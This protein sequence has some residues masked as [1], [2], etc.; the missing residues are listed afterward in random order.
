VT[1][2]IPKWLLWTC[3]GSLAVAAIA[4]AFLLGRS[5]GGSAGE[6]SGDDRPGASSEAQAGECTQRAAERATL[7]SGFAAAIRA[8]GAVLAS[9][10]NTEASEIPFFT[11]DPIDFQVAIVECGD[12]TGDGIDEMVIGLSAGASGR[13]FQ[14]AIF[15]P[16]A[17]GSWDLAFHREGVRVDSVEIF[18]EVV[19]VRTPTFGRNDPLCC[20]SGF[21]EMRIAFRGGRFE[22]TSPAP[23]RRAR[24]IQLHNGRVVRLGPLDPLEASPVQALAEL[25]T[26]T[27][28]SLYPDTVCNVTW[29]DLGLT[30]VFANFG[31]SDPC[32]PNGR[33][34]SFDLR[35]S[36]AA[37]AEWHT[38][39]GAQVGTS[40][41]ELNDLYPGARHSGHELI[42]VET[43]SPFGSAG[44][45]SIA[46]AYVFDG[47]AQAFRFSVGAAGE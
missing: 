30:I 34:A 20:P 27:G 46:T 29:G 42:L 5:S 31:G 32:G 44:T 15:T 47:H 37:Q 39:R 36:P 24:L 40:A 25:G 14:W 38:D 43:P 18:G 26:P 4:S 45:I 17:D 6:P 16:D 8:S 7:G 2:R 13:I 11:G 21:K 19:R 12:L 22:V 28:I 41:T 9:L 1:I 33:I 35:G 23:S 3:C 10:E